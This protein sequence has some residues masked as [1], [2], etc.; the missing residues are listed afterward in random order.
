MKFGVGHAYWGNTGACD[1]EKYKRVAKKLADFGFTMFEVT[2]DHIYHMSEKELAELDAVAREYG[3]TLSTNSGPA[4]EKRSFPAW[5][6][7]IQ[8]SSWIIAERRKI[9]I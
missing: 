8:E 9:W 3:L 5:W 2:A 1:I 4:K 6:I 7:W